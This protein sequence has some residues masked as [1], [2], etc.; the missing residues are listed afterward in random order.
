MST[1]AYWRL[2]VGVR[3][4]DIYAADVSREL[5]GNFLDQF[6]EEPHEVNGLMIGYI[7]MNGRDVGMGVEVAE[8][9]W[10]HEL[11]FENIFDVK[12][13]YKAQIFVPQVEKV[14]NLGNLA[15]KVKVM[16]HIDLG[17]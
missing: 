11:V 1:Y 4:E 5:L 2:W 9:S 15:D 6:S 17:G 14:F 7:H 10:T 3:M 16:H 8:L 13:V 12:K